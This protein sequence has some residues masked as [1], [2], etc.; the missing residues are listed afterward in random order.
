[1][2]T[3]RVFVARLAGMAVFGPDGERIGKVRDLVA[4]LRVDA[5]PP[6]V[7][8]LVVELATRRRI[9]VPMLRVTSID[10]GAVT[11]ATGS[12][13][14]RGF[15]QRPNETLLVGQLI[16]ARV[17]LVESGE[18]VVVVDA[19][20]EPTRSRDWVVGRLAL[21]ARRHGL[22][23]RGPVQVVPW[24]AV[25][26]LSLSDRQGTAGLLA[27]FETMR[28]ADVAA[29]L[30][31]LPEKRQHEVVDSLDDERLAD[32]FEEMSESDQR[33]LLEHLNAER[34]ADVLEAMSPDDAADLLHE[35]PD[36]DADALLALME[37]GESGPVRR[38]MS[39]S[40]DTA[41][42]LM[43]PEPIIL[44]PDATVAEALARIRNPDYPPALA[45]M[46]FVCRPPSET[47]TGRYLGCVHTQRL[48]REAPFD[49]V[50]GVVDTEL[51]RLTP[52]ATLGEI[53]RY[54]AAYNLV[55]GPVVDSEDHLLGAVSVDDVLD[56]LL[57]P[58]WRDRLTEPEG[59][60]DREPD[61]D[62]N[63]D[64]NPEV[65]DA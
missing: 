59:V 63:P 15:A 37:P 16:D 41:G 17:R 64:A 11:L 3:D 34:A 18:E 60:P 54:F 62:A 50:A 1:M 44:R 56:H 30:S 40:S 26:G 45:S 38:L 8:G 14:L 42:G 47:P 43:T 24:N 53:T 2:S 51:A 10:P 32:V 23:R 28:P 35:L 22:S 21:R 55:A 49:L 4:S 9:F 39:Y 46:V 7:L 25:T 31:E 6:R 65:A 13:S 57:P 36:A 33:K 29:A 19:A 12:V 52:D 58:D 5:S 61:H 48:L 20:I 27:V